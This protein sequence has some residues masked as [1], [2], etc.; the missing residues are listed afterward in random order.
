MPST[1]T[2]DGGSVVASKVFPACGSSA[3]SGKPGA[4]AGIM[5]VK[6]RSGGEG[7][8]SG[9]KVGGTGADVARSLRQVLLE[10]AP[11]SLV[12]RRPSPTENVFSLHRIRLECVVLEQCKQASGRAFEQLNGGR[13]VTARR[14]DDAG[15]D[16]LLFI[17]FY[18]LRDG[19]MRE[20]VLQLVILRWSRASSRHANHRRPQFKWLLYSVVDQQLLETVGLKNLGP[21]DVKLRRDT[22]SS[23]SH[24]G[25]VQDGSTRAGWFEVVGVVEL[26]R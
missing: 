19:R 13:H 23:G 1:S 17:L 20:I 22:Q 24:A 25:R 4:V 2:H 11:K 7:V 15:V 10:R 8:G 3:A 6:R 21:K 16:L 5:A 18:Y 9:V 12:G 26:N 14:L